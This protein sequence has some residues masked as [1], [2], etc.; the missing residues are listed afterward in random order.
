MNRG[1]RRRRDRAVANGQLIPEQRERIRAQQELPDD[2]PTPKNPKSVPIP[3]R[4][5]AAMQTISQRFITREEREEVR[6]HQEKLPKDHTS[7]I[8]RTPKYTMAHQARPVLNAIDRSGLV[9]ILEARLRKHP[10]RPSRISIR[11][12]LLCMVLSAELNAT[13]MRADICSV[14]NGLDPQIGYELGL[15]NRD[16]FTLVSYTMVAKQLK[17]LETALEKTWVTADN[18]FCTVDWFCHTFIKATIPRRLRRA[19]TSVSLDWSALRTYAV[20]RTYISEQAAREQQEQQDETQDSNQDDSDQDDSDQ[21]ETQDSNPG[22]ERGADTDAR[23][24]RHTA[25]NKR[26]AGKFVGYNAFIATLAPNYHWAGQLDEIAIEETPPPFITGVALVPANAH[27]G[28]P[29]VKT[30]LNCRDIL[31]KLEQV[32]ADPGF[33]EKRELFNRLLHQARIDMVM[34]Y[35]K[36]KVPKCEPIKA[37]RPEQHLIGYAG[38]IL[39]KY[40]PDKL[41]SVSKHAT[42]EEIKEHATD[43]FKYRW[44]PI[45]TLDDGSIR[46]KCPQCAGKV[47][48]NAKTWAHYNP[49]GTPKRHVKR[50]KKAVP[51]VALIDDEYCCRGTVTIPVDKLDTYQRIPWGTPAW[52]V[53]YARRNQIENVNGM[54]KD[55]HGLQ[56]GWCRILN[57][58]GNTLGLLVLAIAHNL[59]ERKRYRH[60]LQQK[61]ACQRRPVD[62]EPPAD[63]PETAAHTIRGP[64]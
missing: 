36:G 13:Y 22:V 30:V 6:N 41:L 54:L 45:A 44:T 4:I 35:G 2:Q 57:Q 27:I 14:F 63:Q 48:T 53:R 10:G 11:A 16:G 32:I 24:G 7:G 12:L 1:E 60:R 3:P 18:V 8:T 46:F 40:T 25:T 52:F 62:T 49:D 43:L 58:T 19:C 51:R 28:P 59:R 15:W 61:G 21:G 9:P 42:K 34:K 47:R 20:T 26:K 29:G 31:N 5:R 56:D 50:P 55:R 33:S 17:R 64:P 23:A 38:M 37:G 39:A